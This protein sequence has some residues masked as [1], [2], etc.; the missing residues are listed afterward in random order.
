MSNNEPISVSTS[1]GN[2]D[3]GQKILI[4]QFDASLLNEK[5]I[6]QTVAKTI[7]QIQ[8]RIKNVES[9]S[10]GNINV[11]TLDTSTL[12]VRLFEDNDNNEKSV[13]A[14]CN[15]VDVEIQVVTKNKIGSTR[16]IIS[17][18]NLNLSTDLKKTIEQITEDAFKNSLD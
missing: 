13:E 1:I 11:V 14:T 2:N 17:D 8:P 16:A 5:G 3:N 4:I 9:L 15:I 18:P 6:K 7:N 12:D 10:N